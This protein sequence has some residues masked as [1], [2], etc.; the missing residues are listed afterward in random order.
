MCVLYFMENTLKTELYFEIKK[1]LGR[2][3][4]ASP[5]V[6]GMCTVCLFYRWKVCILYLYMRVCV[7]VCMCAFLG[8][9]LA[10]VAHCSVH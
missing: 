5:T 2:L 7:C 3:L 10:V 8:K 9:T 1:I 4:E 6:T